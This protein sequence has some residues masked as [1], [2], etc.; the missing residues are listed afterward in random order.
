MTVLDQNLRVAASN[1]NIEQM[2]ALIAAG[3]DV[4]A[5]AD[6]GSALHYAVIHGRTASVELLIEHGAQL[7]GAASSTDPR[8]PLCCALCY[9]HRTL[10]K[11]LLRAGAVADHARVRSGAIRPL[12]R[13]LI[14]SVKAAGGWKP[15]A[16]KHKRVLVGLVT[17]CKPIP[18]DAA[19]LV[20][21]F[22]CPEGG[23]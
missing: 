20:V 5:M 13:L 18:D 6:W 1:G 2:R 12:I 21:E 11:I 15:Y 17:K 22:Y 14:D 23:Y 4:R 19:G 16:A 7:D 10:A 3:A 9:G 8:T